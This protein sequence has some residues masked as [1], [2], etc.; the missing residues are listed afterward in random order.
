MNILT[1]K[2]I[3]STPISRGIVRGIFLNYLKLKLSKIRKKNPFCVVFI[4]TPLH[5]NLGDQAIVHAQHKIFKDLIK[6]DNIVEIPAPLYKRFWKEIHE[7]I[8]DKDII[9]IDGGGNMGTLWIEVEHKMQHIVENF[10]S[11]KII[12][13]PQTIFYSDDAYGDK[14][15]KQSV[16]IYSSH[17]DL[18]IC[19]REH[20]TYEFMM[21]V[22]PSSNILLVPDIVLYLDSSSNKKERNGALICLREDKEQSFSKDTYKIIDRKLKL[23]NISSSKISTLESGIIGSFNRKRHLSKKLNQFSG[24]KIIVTDRLHG[25]IFAAITATP[26][27]AFDNSS[28]KVGN[29]YKWIQHLPYIS[30]VEDNKNIEETIECLLNL[31]PKYYPR[32][33]IVNKFEPLIQT[34]DQIICEEK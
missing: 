9:V 23:K 13:F 7:L 19:A 14:E 11:N 4:S 15:L 8:D 22:Y 34:I 30:F 28:G 18:Y 2:K 17:P 32:D 10:S 1:L 12:I 6:S 24:A 25:M 27:L 26:C 33:E 20:R 16:E 5:G 21:R 3:F 29:V 31:E